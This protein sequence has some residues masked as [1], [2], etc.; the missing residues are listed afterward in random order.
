MHGRRRGA[1]QTNDVG[2]E[3]RDRPVICLLE[4]QEDWGRHRLC[5]MAKIQAGANPPRP[6]RRRLRALSRTLGK[7]SELEE[8]A[9]K[10]LSLCSWLGTAVISAEVVIHQRLR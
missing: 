5:K 1:R 8:G 6:P 7:H 9:N 10:G 4:M 2:L 3:R